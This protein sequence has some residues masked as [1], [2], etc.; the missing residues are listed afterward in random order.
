MF[1]HPLRIDVQHH[2]TDYS[3]LSE[4][5][6]K[7]QDNSLFETAEQ[8]QGEST[9]KAVPPTVSVASSELLHINRKRRHATSSASDTETED[10]GKMPTKKH[11]G[12]DKRHSSK[13]KTKNDD[14]ADVTEPE[15]RRRIQNRI[16]QRKFRKIT[17]SL[18]LRSLWVLPLPEPSPKRRVGY[19]PLAQ[20]RSISTNCLSG[21]KAKEQKD[22]TERDSRN[23]EH[24]GS[25]YRVPDGESL[26]DEDGD[27]SGLPWGGINMRHVVAWGHESERGSGQDDSYCVQDPAV[28]TAQY[29]Y[30]NQDYYQNHYAGGD[31]GG[32][33][34]LGYYQQYQQDQQQQNTPSSGIDDGYLNDSQSTYPYY[35][36]PFN[37]GA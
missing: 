25:T 2:L 27:V 6:R 9:P 36:S 24:A 14:W 34:G 3:L 18:T 26:D 22:K 35:Y 30:L 12:S 21:E 7:D 23:Q 4:D 33:A 31:G 19:M 11:S 37:H 32:D 28:A 8:P 10:A 29:Q 20:V 17:Q 13:S 1:P 5:L 16:A 15:E